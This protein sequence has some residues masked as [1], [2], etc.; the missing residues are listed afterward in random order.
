MTQ[1][2]INFGEHQ[3]RI[4]TI[5]KGKY[6]LRNKSEAANFIIGQY[7]KNL[8]EPELRPEYRNELLKIDKGKFRAF[9]STED[10]RKEIENARI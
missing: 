8:L 1:A 7:E 6:G 4:L 9:K 10:L 5:I 3:N 2:V